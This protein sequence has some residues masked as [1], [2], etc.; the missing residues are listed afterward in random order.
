MQF[1][2]TDFSDL[3]IIEPQIF[4]DHRGYFYESFHLKKFHQATGLHPKFVQ[5]NQSKSSYGVLRGLHFQYGEFAQSKLV[6]V[7][8][9]KVWDWVVDLRSDSPTFGKSFGIELSVE[10]RKQ[11]YIP[12]GFAHGFVVLSKTAEFAYKCDNFYAPNHES[13][14]IYNDPDLKMD[15]QIPENEQIIS[16]KDKQLLSFSQITEKQYF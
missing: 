5:D 11:L 16:E 2:R 8:S 1:I 12:K 3:W 10:N 6:R 13:G 15:W 9:G 7:L 14:I 4:G